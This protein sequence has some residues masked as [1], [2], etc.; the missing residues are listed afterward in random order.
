MAPLN[1]YVSFY[2]SLFK[3]LWTLVFARTYAPQKTSK[4]DL[5]GQ[6]A[7]VTGA[8][9]GIGLSIA[10]QLARQG[11]TVYLA[12]RSLE[13]GAKAIDKIA[14]KTGGKCEGRV[15]CWELDTSDLTNVRAFCSRWAQ[16][17]QKIDMLVHNAGIAAPPSNSPQTTKDVKDLVIV[18]NFLGSFLMTHLLE[19]SLSPTARIVLTSS[20]GHYA[21]NRFLKAPSSAP[22]PIAR[23]TNA[24]WKWA[25]LTTSAPA[26]AHSKAQQVL[27]AHLLQQH[28]SSSQR[29][30]HAFT[31]GFTSTAIFGKFDVTWRTWLSNPLFAT[32]KATERYVAVDTDQ[33]SRM[34][35]W[36]A[37]EGS[38]MNG[39]GFWEWGVRRTSLVDLLRG[40]LG[41]KE[42]GRKARQEWDL[43]ERDVGVQWDFRLR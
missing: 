12:C 30:A 40:A 13:R 4:R 19:P 14:S 6:I 1:I 31:P 34:G 3:A 39:G 10:T 24:V 42:F 33:G 32:L 22:G 25:G 36:L 7:I 23:L 37:A 41:E 11:A 29:S 17:G 9:S 43:W 26:Y 27:F 5:N 38:K 20:S 35:S 2:S 28:F 18:T 8:N 16:G 15:Q 21:A